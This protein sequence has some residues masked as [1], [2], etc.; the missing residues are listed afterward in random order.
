[1]HIPSHLQTDSS[2]YYLVFPTVSRLHPARRLARVQTQVPIQILGL[3]LPAPDLARLPRV[4]VQIL[5]LVRLLK[6][7][8]VANTGVTAAHLP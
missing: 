5:V 7:H 4:L 2:L 6:R 8:R 3:L 1:M